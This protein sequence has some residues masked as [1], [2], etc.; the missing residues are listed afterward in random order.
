MQRQ[1]LVGLAHLCDDFWSG[2]VAAHIIWYA[3]WHLGHMLVLGGKV[4]HRTLAATPAMPWLAAPLRL[5]LGAATI[6]LVHYALLGLLLQLAFRQAATIADVVR[7]CVLD[8][9]QRAG[10]RLR[11]RANYRGKATA[12]IQ[13]PMLDIAGPSKRRVES[14]K[15]CQL[16]PPALALV[17][18]F[19]MSVVDVKNRRYFY[20]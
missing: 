2:V 14:S 9:V 12:A 4:R 8:G 17:P 7:L 5:T 16:R 11:P 18:A 20:G 1:A 19:S 10:N 6:L 15:S 3:R 13:T